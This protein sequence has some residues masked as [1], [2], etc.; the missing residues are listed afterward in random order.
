MFLLRLRCRHIKVPRHIVR[1]MAKG[2]GVVVEI[3]CGHTGGI[4]IVLAHNENRMVN[5]GTTSKRSE[6]PW[7]SSARRSRSI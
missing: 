1:I 5:E 6:T 7:M 3:T 2:L 4:G